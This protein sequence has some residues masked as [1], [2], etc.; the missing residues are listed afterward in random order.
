VIPQIKQL[1]EPLRSQVRIAFAE[2]CTIIWYALLGFAAVGFI[3][4]W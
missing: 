3:A 2:S 4:S 1:P